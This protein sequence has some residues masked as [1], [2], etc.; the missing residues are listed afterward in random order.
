MLQE[1]NAD[2]VQAARLAWWSARDRFRRPSRSTVTWIAVAVGVLALAI[3]FVALVKVRPAFDAYGW[4]V[5]G[6]Q[7][8]H[9]GLNTDAAPSW[10]PLTFLFTFPYALLTGRSALYVWM[11]T[12]VAAG[13]AAPIFAGRV[14]YRLAGPDTLARTARFGGAA[15]AGLAV[16]GLEG[17]WH[18]ILISTA[19]PMM[20]ALSLWAL[21]CAVAGRHRATWVLLVLTC[22]GRPE[23]ALVVLAYGVW[24]WVRTPRVRWLVVAGLVS[25]PALWFGIPALTSRSWLIAGDVLDQSTT[26]I[27]GSKF[28]GVL[29]YFTSLYELPMQL[30]VLAAVI[31]GVLLRERRW[32][33][34]TLAALSWLV[35]DFGLALH[36]SGL[37][38]RYLFEPAAI[39]LAITGAGAGRVLSFDPR[40][41]LVLRWAGV[42]ALVVLAVTMLSPA[43]LRARLAHNGILLGQRWALQIHRLHGVIDADGGLAKVVACGTPVTTI[44]YQSILAWETDR[45]VSAI[46]WSPAAWEH[47]RQPMVLFSPDGTGWKVTAMDEPRADA[48]RCARLDRTTA[49]DQHGITLTNNPTTTTTT[50][51]SAH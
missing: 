8:A 30:A 20:V 39:L 12:A 19:D 14:A 21:D 38:P 7:A 15:F 9:G 32:L 47:L 35:V 33:L 16:L 6:R 10:K 42:G 28:L 29:N 13:M 23:A 40:I 45:N 36:G 44:P 11:V 37:A 2:S 49:V 3:A 51:T 1:R 50:T 18:F 46:G 25:I 22:L 17:Y 31:G 24:I 43:R 41:M 48:A 26:P 5:W 27:A 4:L 34:A